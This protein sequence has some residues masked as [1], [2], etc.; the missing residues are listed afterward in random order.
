MKRFLSLVAFAVALLSPGL[1]HAASY[2][3]D[4]AAISDFYDARGGA[5][6]FGEPISREFT[7][8]GSQVQIF[9]NA[10]LRLAPDGS[11]QL[12]QLTDSSLLPYTSLNGLTVPAADPSVSFVAP[13]PDQPNYAARLEGYLHGVVSPEFLPVYDS[14][15]WGLPTSFA[16]VDPNNP[17][18]LYQRF[19][20]G[21]LFHD[22]GTGSTQ[23][24]PLGEYFTE[25]LTRQN[26]PTD[27][28]T[29]AATSPFLGLAPTD[30]FVPNA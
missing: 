16:A 30:A 9:Q 5:T 28:A 24:L 29:E 4:D 2:E 6:T 25:I 21:I 23:A 22:S 7:L 18:F 1:A 13:S 15:I 12:L 3:L 17:S 14:D 19:E 20:N 26:L 27:L 11:V 10:V 8:A